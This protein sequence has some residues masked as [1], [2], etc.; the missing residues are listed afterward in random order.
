MNGTRSGNEDRVTT[1]A[2]DI[3]ITNKIVRI[4]LLY[5]DSVFYYEICMHLTF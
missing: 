2:S 1:N 5:Y 3:W 4:Y